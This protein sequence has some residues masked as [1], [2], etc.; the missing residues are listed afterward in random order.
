MARTIVITG[1]NRGIGR[2][3]VHALA[4]RPEPLR[5]VMVCRDPVSGALTR[6][7]IARGSSAEI[8]LVTGSL[9][10][11]RAI[12]A[13]AEQIEQAC[14]RIDA[15]IHNAGVWPAQRKLNSD[16]LEQAFVVNHLAPFVL[17]R[18]LES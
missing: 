4:A 1:A 18:R 9:D 12:H 10:N 3:L 16:G 11:I 17:N 5:I 6:D 15:L 14:P 7:E 2:A 13:A 8:A